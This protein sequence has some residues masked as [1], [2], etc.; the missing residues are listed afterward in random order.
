VTEDSSST[1][2]S[3]RTR[4][5]S[6]RRARPTR[7]LNYPARV[8]HSFRRGAD[9]IL[10]A[11]PVWSVA[12]VLLTMVLLG[13]QRCG[14]SY[15]PYAVGDIAAED[16]RVKYDIDLPDEA[17]TEARR[18]EARD[19]VPD[20]YV[21]DTERV[22]RLSGELASLF[23]E[24]RTV[25]EAA[26]DE[27][28]RRRRASLESRFGQESIA[29]LE[30]HGFSTAL[31]RSS[32]ALLRRGMRGLV[33]GNTALLQ[34]ETEVLVLHVP[35]G[36]EERLTGFG[37]IVDLDGA[38]ERTRAAAEEVLELPATDRA[39]VAGL[40]ASF[41]DANFSLDSEG[42]HARRR[43]A[44]D[45]VPP[46]MER[47]A[48]GTVIA[49]QGEKISAEVY[50][51]L[52]S[53]RRA[54]SGRL[55]LLDLAGLALIVSLLG[56]FLWRYASY[57]QRHFKKIRHLHALLVL[58]MLS[59]LLLA[60]AI[61]WLVGEVVDRFG[62]PFN[63]VQHYDYLVPLGAGSILITLLANGRIA[64]VY[65]AF[66]S[67]LYGAVNGWDAELMTW[68][69]LVQWAGV[70][71]ISTYRERTALLRAG[72][73]VG[74]AGALAALALQAMQGT[75]DPLSGSLYAAALA[76]LGGAV[77][78]GVVVSFTLPL[79]EG[80]FRVLTDVR[81]L[82]LS[83]LNNPLLSELA[84]KAPGSYNHSLVVGTLAEE[85]AKAIGANSLFCRVAAFYHDI[86]KLL[87]PDYYVE[88]QRGT[89]PHDGLSPSMSA[90]VVAAHVKDGIK[91]AREAGLPEQI[92]DIIPQHHG[93]R[94]MKYFY[95]KAKQ[96]A[97]PGLGPI[98]EED[99]RYPGPKPQTREAAIFMLADSVEAAA[100][101]VEEPTRN[102]MSE[103]VRKVSN[104]IVLDGQF[105]ECDLTFVDL[106]RI[107]EAFLRALTSM[108]H[109]RVDYPGFDFNK[110]DKGE[111]PEA[112][113]GADPGSGDERRVARGGR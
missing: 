58:V 31:E 60:Q 91:L 2:T 37:T 92:V 104:A 5:R 54:S 73:V 55:G 4:E 99:F 40:V 47:V 62:P 29:A 103:M 3:T 109:H 78:V 49:R 15:E 33:I 50:E 10:G 96:S 42:T 93:T 100:R 71:A 97:D 41:V 69:L 80:L 89:N 63:E 25:I 61:L 6:N 70:Y 44:A 83:N 74:G 95:E 76:F 67:L 110:P 27:G 7:K 98:K 38:R 21:H 45:A 64:M 17:E 82:E 32:T 94:L 9:R 112:R 87:K 59:T 34:R 23:R 1:R 101:T 8:R 53:A 13:S 65:A 14:V 12:F 30:R 72:L 18:A 85:G 88:N 39:A 106:N 56:F 113:G 43:A 86:G 35:E 90:L 111:K 46:V 22:V 84:V 105:E 57:H 16:I 77:G 48:K 81:L 11:D 52:E 19:A 51:R 24:G 66:T 108:Y 26:D 75:L 36:R 102:R 79:L 28:T 107:H 68:S 20:L